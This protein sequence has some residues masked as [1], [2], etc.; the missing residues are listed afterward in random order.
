MPRAA[1]G[2]RRLEGTQEPGWRD[3]VA[4]GWEAGRLS[5]GLPAARLTFCW[6]LCGVTRRCLRAAP[7]GS[8]PEVTGVEA[9]GGGA[10]GGAS[11][12]WCAARAPLGGQRSPRPSQW[13]GVL[14]T[15]SVGRLFS[16]WLALPRTPVGRGREPPSSDLPRKRA[17]S[18]FSLPRGSLHSAALGSSTRPPSR[19]LCSVS[20][21]RS[22][23]AHTCF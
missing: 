17:A 22:A 16:L 7:P 9:S 14:L 10:V 3:G 21:W 18:C 23:T 4:G 20:V 1:C 6:S 19:G 5:P 12:A 15:L 8:G 11:L 13:A 2:G